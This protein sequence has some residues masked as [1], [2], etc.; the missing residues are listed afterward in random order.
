MSYKTRSFWEIISR[1]VSPDRGQSLPSMWRDV[2]ESP[3]EGTDCRTGAP[4]KKQVPVS[5]YPKPDSSRL[6]AKEC[7]HRLLLR[8]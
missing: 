3:L 1:L 6:R 8:R 2:I 7:V 4:L 5:R